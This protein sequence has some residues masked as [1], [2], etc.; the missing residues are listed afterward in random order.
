MLEYTTEDLLL[1]LYGEAPAE[2][3][4]AIS[5]ALKQDWELRERVDVLRHSMDILDSM[6]ESPRPQSVQAILAY[7]GVTAPIEEQQ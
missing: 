5:E 6:I 2:Q 4:R 1:Y 7:A 3:A